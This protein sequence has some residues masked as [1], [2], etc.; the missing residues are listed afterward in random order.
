MTFE[1]WQG[2]DAKWSADLTFLDNQLELFPRFSR[3]YSVSSN[4]YFG[5]LVM[6]KGLVRINIVIWETGLIN[7]N[8]ISF[9]VAFEISCKS[10]L[11]NLA[12]YVMPNDRKTL[13]LCT[14]NPSSFNILVG[15][16][17]Y[18]GVNLKGIC[19]VSRCMDHLFYCVLMVIL[20][21]FIL[22]SKFHLMNVTFSLRIC[23]IGLKLGGVIK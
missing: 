13:C 17:E 3:W 23:R 8:I 16:I 6:W 4:E 12:I 18:L 11:L 7:V 21:H 14:T 9:E 20:R 19:H 1:Y 22:G 2:C 5:Y 15:N 10:G